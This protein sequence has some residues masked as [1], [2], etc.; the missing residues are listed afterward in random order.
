MTFI[1]LCCDFIG[2]QPGKINFSDMQLIEAI[3][4]VVQ[5]FL[6]QRKKLPNV[7]TLEDVVKVLRESK[8]IMVLTGAGVCNIFYFRKKNFLLDE[9]HNII[10]MYYEMI[11]FLCHAVFL[12]FDQKMAFILGYL[13][14]TWMT[15]KICSIS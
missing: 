8:N 1:M 3:S 4:K 7:N 10:L 15:H 13:N 6:R 12:I 11:R 2:L 5:K 9:I 14:L